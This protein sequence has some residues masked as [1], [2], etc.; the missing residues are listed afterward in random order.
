MVFMAESLKRPLWV[1]P[2]TM[3]NGVRRYGTPVRYNWGWHPARSDADLKAFGP[4]YVDYR[5]AIVDVSSL[6][7]IKAFD[8]VWMDTEPSDPTDPLASDADFYVYGQPTAGPG[9]V[10]QVMFRKLSSDAGQ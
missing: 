6:D 8:R 4:Q 3:V 5:R 1:A 10:V 2:G 7:N 9:G